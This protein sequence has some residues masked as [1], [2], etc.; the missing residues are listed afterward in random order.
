VNYPRPK[1]AG[2][3]KT[4]SSGAF[5][6]NKFM[7]YR[8]ICRIRPLLETYRFLTRD[9]RGNDISPDELMD[10]V[11]EPKIIVRWG[12]DRYQDELIAVFPLDDG[13]DEQKRFHVILDDQSATIERESFQFEAAPIV[14]YLLSRWPQYASFT[15]HSMPSYYS[16]TALGDVE[17]LA[18]LAKHTKRPSVTDQR[19]WYHGTSSVHAPEILRLGLRPQDADNRQY[20]GMHG[21][22]ENMVYLTSDIDTAEFHAKN[23][24]K[25]FGGAPTVLRIDISGLEANIRTDHDVRFTPLAAERNAQNQGDLKRIRAKPGQASY[26]GLKTISFAGRIPPSR[27]SILSQ[28]ADTKAAPRLQKIAGQYEFLKAL[29]A[30]TSGIAAAYMDQFFHIIGA[31]PSGWTGTT[32]RYPDSYRENVPLLINSIHNGRQ[33][34]ASYA[35]WIRGMYRRTGAWRTRGGVYTQ[36]VT[37][38]ADEIKRLS[39]V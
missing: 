21:S 3:S 32:K 2:A 14:K 18:D 35:Q 37:L 26:M 9:E 29:G 11:D 8:E 7:R 33:A 34:P 20:R 15:L 30:L 23:S 6:I 4:K 17:T 27:I 38:I 39:T 31:Q 1:E 5:L 16:E 24:V 25:H 36:I 12:R 28:G 10:D 13:Y 22:K 19:I